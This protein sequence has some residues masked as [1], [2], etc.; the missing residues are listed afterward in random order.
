MRH[1]LAKVSSHFSV[2][3]KRVSSVKK[4]GKIVRF[5]RTTRERGAESRKCIGVSS[6]AADQSKRGVFDDATIF[7]FSFDFSIFK[8]PTLS[9]LSSSLIPI[10]NIIT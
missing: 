5:R 1:R 9:R 6:G 8:L 7:S 2:A 3:E 4:S 10:Q